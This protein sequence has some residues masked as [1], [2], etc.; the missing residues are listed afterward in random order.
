MTKYLVRT[1]FPGNGK[2]YKRGEVLTET[3]VTGWPNLR[4][5]VKADYLEVL[6]E[7]KDTEEVIEDSRANVATTQ[8][9]I[10]RVRKKK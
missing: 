1:G 8:A 6:V 7:E 10:R 2:E 3:D 5:L 4:S 9:K